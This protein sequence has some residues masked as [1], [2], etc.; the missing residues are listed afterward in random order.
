MDRSS[1]V[2]M[3][4]SSLPGNYGIGTMGKSAYKFVDFLRDSGQKYWQLLPLCPTSYGDSPY[5]SF[6]TFAG[7]PY[8]IDLDLLC[9]DKLLKKAEYADIDWGC[10]PAKV[11]YGKIYQ[12]RFGVLRLA[13]GRGKK[14]YAA[15]EADIQALNAR[16]EALRLDLEALV[17]A[18]ADA[19]TPLAAAYK[20]PKETPEQQAHKAAV[21]E[22]ALEGAC[23]VPL[24]IMSACCEGIA[25]VAEYAEKGSVM[26]VS[27]AGCAALFCKAALQAAGLNVSINTRLMADKAHAAALNAQA[28]AMLAEFVPQA[29]QI[30]EKLTHSLRG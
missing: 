4:M 8:L 20:L 25:L 1:G 6:S 14:K 9:R 11:D 2:L 17:Q 16:A 19:F 24:E 29:D 10:D 13:Y 22:A 18:D 3:A 15:V 30:Y 27:D 7:N 26:A 5:S 28:D 23:A 12:H 21:L